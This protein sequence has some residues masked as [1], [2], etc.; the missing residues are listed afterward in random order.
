MA[1]H[2][3]DGQELT[4]H[5]TIKAANGTQFK[6]LTVFSMSLRYFRQLATEQLEQQF[7][8]KFSDSR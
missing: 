8:S 6:A 5:T 1:L 4:K 2:T 3:K 7:G